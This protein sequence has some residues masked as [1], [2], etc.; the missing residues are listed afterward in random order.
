[1]HV[2]IPGQA[3]TIELEVM[4]FQVSETVRHILFPGLNRFLPYR[5][6]SALDSHFTSDGTEVAANYQ[7][8]ANAALAQL[9]TSKVQIVMLLKFV[10]AELVADTK[11][12]AVRRAVFRDEIDTSDLSFFATVFSM[13]RNGQRGEWPAQDR[14]VAFVKPFGGGADF[15]FLRSPTSKA[16]LKHAHTVSLWFRCVCRRLQMHRLPVL[17]A[18]QVR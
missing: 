3:M 5:C 4:M 15:A 2:E 13:S 6:A 8:R 11:T 14:A 9:R 16:R 10:I 12:D 18:P 1:M 17:R 7:F